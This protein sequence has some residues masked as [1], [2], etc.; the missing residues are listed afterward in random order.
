MPEMIK[1][2]ERSGL[3]FTGREIK[4]ETNHFEITSLPNAN[5]HHYDVIIA[6]EVPPSLN[7][8]IFS[9]F[10]LQQRNALGEMNPVFNGRRNLYAVNP[11][12][13]GDVSTFCVTLEEE[14]EKQFEIKIK[15]V[16]V[17]DLR[18]LRECLGGRS[19]VS[20]NVLNG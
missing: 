16:A 18:D 10:V 13:F 1:I 17:I 19:P 9:E 5:I 8:R 12:P 6:P 4:V 3:G 20:A 7:R 15:K 2:T 14:Q 11:L